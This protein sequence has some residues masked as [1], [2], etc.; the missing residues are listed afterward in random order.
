MRLLRVP[1]LKVANARRCRVRVAGEKAGTRARP[2]GIQSV[3]R[4]RR[5]GW[6]RL[7]SKQR[8]KN[9]L[10]QEGTS[11]DYVRGEV[12]TREGERDGAKLFSAIVV[13]AAALR[14]HPSPK[15]T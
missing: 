11:R 5:V 7:S 14:D 12:A 13:T 3:E 1:L 4:R 8:A 15:D 6:Q 10:N 2:A 9:I